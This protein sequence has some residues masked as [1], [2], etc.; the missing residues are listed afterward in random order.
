M[1]RDP[2][3]RVVWRAKLLRPL[4]TRQFARFGPHS[5][6]HKPMWISHGDQIEIGGFLLALHGLWISVEKPAWGKGT[7]LRIGERVGI[8]PYV[9]ISASE[10]IT[11]EDNVVLSAF[12][13]V[14]DSDHTFAA[15]RPNILHN[16]S[17][18]APVRVG[19]GTWVA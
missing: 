19:E 11:I 18:T 10:S 14:I 13:S 15:G 9:T 5:I 3:Q 1:L 12:C 16:P 17:V 8:R 6:V 2:L 4:R 7:A